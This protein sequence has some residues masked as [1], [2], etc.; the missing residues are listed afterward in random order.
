MLLG[1]KSGISSRIFI[2]GGKLQPSWKENA[3]MKLQSGVVPT[4]EELALLGLSQAE[5]QQMAMIY[6]NQ[7][8]GLY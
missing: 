2:P 3:W 6:R 5:A 7:M 1:Q 8:M 4:A